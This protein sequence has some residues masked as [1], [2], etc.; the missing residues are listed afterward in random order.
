MR[1]DAIARIYPSAARRWFGAV[2]LAILGLLLVWTSL[3]YP[4][5]NFIWTLI[6][7][8]FGGICIWGAYAAY[9]ATGRG[10]ELT[11]EGLFDTDGLVLARMEDVRSVVSGPLAFKPSNGFTVR[12]KT[13]QKFG[14]A[15]GLWWRMGRMVG[16][17]GMTTGVE[18][19]F[20]AEMIAKLIAER[21]GTT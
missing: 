17:G 16:V 3:A 18:G 14:W 11:R 12:L 1:D 5:S 20:M 4:S 6:L 2:T 7:L 9:Q 13:R 15:P 8:G 21:D 19:K 10:I